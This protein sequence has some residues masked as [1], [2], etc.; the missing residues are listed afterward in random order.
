MARGALCPRD[1]GCDRLTHE[2]VRGHSIVIGCLVVWVC[3]CVPV[4]SF[5]V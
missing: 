4:V 2:H 1:Q 3:W 5:S